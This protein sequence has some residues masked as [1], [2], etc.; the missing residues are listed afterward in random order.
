MSNKT[1]RNNKGSNNSLTNQQS[2]GSEYHSEHAGSVEGY[3]EPYPNNGS[4]EN[5]NNTN[6]K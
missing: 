5:M 2:S 6:K 1:N 3:G 4:I